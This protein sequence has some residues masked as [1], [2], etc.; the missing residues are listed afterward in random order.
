MIDK[1]PN[2]Q[3]EEPRSEPEIIPPTEVVV[4]EPQEE[5]GEDEATPP[6]T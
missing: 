4:D 5:P 1:R 3:S 6:E 2:M